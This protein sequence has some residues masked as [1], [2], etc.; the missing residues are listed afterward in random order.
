MGGARG[1]SPNGGR[2]TRQQAG[3]VDVDMMFDFA[4]G[5]R[6]G[7]PAHWG[8][9]DDD[10]DE[11]YDDDDYE[12][13][14]DDEEEYEDDDDEYEDDMGPAAVGRASI[15]RDAPAL[16]G[17]ARGP[18]PVLPSSSSKIRPA[19]GATKAYTDRQVLFSSYDEARKLTVGELKAL[20]RERNVDYSGC[21]EKPELLA[22]LLEWESANVGACTHALSDATSAD[23]GYP[24]RGGV[25]EAAYNDRR[26]DDDDTGCYEDDDSGRAAGTQ[27]G[28]DVAKADGGAADCNM[29]TKARRAARKKA[30][31]KRKKERQ[32]AERSAARSGVDDENRQA[33]DAD[34]ADDEL[35][36]GKD[37]RDRHKGDDGMGEG[38]LNKKAQHAT[39]PA[40][41]KNGASR[42]VDQ[43]R[44]AT[45]DDTAIHD[46]SARRYSQL[47]DEVLVDVA[48]AVDAGDARGAARALEAAARV[49]LEPGGQYRALFEHA[50]RLV[51]AADE[52]RDADAERQKAKEEAAKRK[53]EDK[54][55]RREARRKALADKVEVEERERERR[56][57]ER[58]EKKAAK[59]KERNASDVDAVTEVSV[60]IPSTPYVPYKVSETIKRP[61]ND[62]LNDHNDRDM[63]GDDCESDDRAAVGKAAN[64]RREGDKRLI[65]GR[66]S[67]A[68]R[69]ANIGK[70]GGFKTGAVS[71]APAA[72][73]GPEATAQAPS[74]KARRKSKSRDPPSKPIAEKQNSIPMDGPNKS[75]LTA[76]SHSSKKS[77][78]APVVGSIAT[79]A[80]DEDTT[81][82]PP[83]AS[84][85]DTKLNG[86]VPAP[87]VNTSD[88]H[89]DLDQLEAE[90][91]RKVL[92]MSLDQA[93]KEEEERKA[94]ARAVERADLA[95]RRER[96]RAL[97]REWNSSQRRAAVQQSKAREADAR[98]EAELQRASA[99]A[100]AVAL[101]GLPGFEDLAG[102]RGG[103]SSPPVLTNFPP[104]LPSQPSRG[105]S[106]QQSV[107]RASVAPQPHG[108]AGGSK[109]SGNQRAINRSGPTIPS[110]NSATYTQSTGGTYDDED[111][112]L[113]LAE[114][115]VAGVLDADDDDDLYDS[116]G[117]GLLR[118]R[119]NRAP[120]AAVS[121][122]KP[123]LSSIGTGSMSVVKG[124]PVFVG[125]A[126]GGDSLEQSALSRSTSAGGR[127]Q[128]PAQRA[129]IHDA[130][131]PQRSS[132]LQAHAPP[133]TAGCG[134][135]GNGQQ[136]HQQLSAL[137][138]APAPAG[139]RGPSPPTLP[140]APRSTTGHAAVPP[141]Q[142]GG[143]Q[144]AQ[145]RTGFP[146]ANPSA[147]QSQ[148]L[149]IG[150]APIYIPQ[151]Q[152]A[153]KPQSPPPSGISP[154]L[155][156][157]KQPPNSAS[158]TPP[159]GPPGNVAAASSYARSVS[160][161][162]QPSYGASQQPQQQQYSSVPRSVTAPYVAAPGT[163]AQPRWIGGDATTRGPR[164][165][166]TPGGPPPPSLYNQR[167][168]TAPPFVPAH[169]RGVQ[170]M[171]ATP[172]G[173][174]GVVKP[175]GLAPRGGIAS[176]PGGVVGA[177]FPSPY[178]KVSVPLTA[179]PSGL[180]ASPQQQ[181]AP[182]A[183]PQR[184][185]HLT[186]VPNA[187]NVGH[188]AR[189]PNLYSATVRGAST[190]V[191]AN[192]QRTNQQRPL[193][194][195]PAP[196]RL[197]QSLPGG[198][199]NG[200][201]AFEATR[202]S[203]AAAASQRSALPA[204]GPSR[205]DS[206]SPITIESQPRWSAP[207]VD[208]S[209]RLAMEMSRQSELADALS[210]LDD[211]P[212]PPTS[213]QV[214]KASDVDA[215]LA[216]AV[217]TAAEWVPASVREVRAKQKDASAHLTSTSSVD[218]LDGSTN[219]VALRTP[220]TN[221]NP[222]AVADDVDTQSLAA[223]SSRK[224]TAATIPREVS[225]DVPLVTASQPV[226]T[227]F[228]PGA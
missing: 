104:A 85:V 8:V 140:S 155:Q 225:T 56:E 162:Q 94:A 72:S 53:I 148:L 112:G 11:D 170:Q 59:K 88:D 145:Q 78:S 141:G 35:L 43:A 144:S 36:L 190:V 200:T 7:A 120:A 182:V 208:D 44:D 206:A 205:H 163:G 215:R 18:V 139:A 185:A 95:S 46:D 125:K 52:R 218:A 21:L 213:A 219:I 220:I 142:A 129:Y 66:A 80:N 62:V 149:A 103:Q 136:Q 146:N 83:A 57:A 131:R 42:H 28:S 186:G 178:A 68:S 47:R 133:F 34:V 98:R 228:K 143:G 191:N 77:A 38:A 166:G 33:D 216:A 24:C 79:S 69:H 226:A 193:Q 101:S 195:Q 189:T 90:Q 116:S 64:T 217:S 84:P 58:R 212:V 181:R 76:N 54:R 60:A 227:P 45:C 39:L 134:V 192:A 180:A 29:S 150:G 157:G 174:P 99:T 223:A 41:T 209:L 187:A 118:D 109:I 171:Q 107:A 23:D 86:A 160:V 176:A 73:T 74:S 214:R 50:A 164:P 1:S 71:A 138:G 119:S 121:G 110:S 17:L 211:S 165:Q 169:Q 63:D 152:S 96:E 15:S 27:T 30:Q 124:P 13:E 2:G 100:A 19:S 115:S 158:L 203:L 108:G 183:G 6:R 172:R 111:D 67:E 175:V 137:Y 89:M 26:D 210:T 197:Q 147:M 202:L 113:H 40:G 37:H 31:Q 198:S 196:S 9:M 184:P 173:P 224:P 168:A 10:E 91:L 122:P 156:A 127:P 222:I 20:L 154:M 4:F 97:Q 5:A 128:Q 177:G 75:G 16:G 221:D 159:P 117:G 51:K 32:K 126:F 61:D 161:Q 151:H 14:E 25:S 82:L 194:Q 49:G 22:L 199:M 93:A 123:K 12:Y 55:A 106:V 70:R 105:R 135:Q 188:L 102:P 87:D 130:P 92:Q 81:E 153:G 3:F 114:Q 132:S 48:N 207:A 179:P 204:S 201:T 167:L 65:D